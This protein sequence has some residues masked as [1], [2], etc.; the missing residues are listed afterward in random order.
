MDST[1]LRML[2]IR[3]AQYITMLSALFIQETK[4]IV[5]MLQSFEDIYGQNKIH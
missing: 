2:D 3:A 1:K 4:C 5:I